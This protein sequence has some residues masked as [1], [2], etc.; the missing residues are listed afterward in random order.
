MNL[1][2]LIDKLGAALGGI[3]YRNNLIFGKS[4]DSVSLPEAAGATVA[5]VD[6]F[7]EGSWQPVQAEGPAGTFNGG[8]LAYRWLGY[9]KPTLLYMHGS[10]E[11]PYNFGRFSDNSFKKIFSNAVM[12]DLNLFLL[13]AP[14]HDRSQGEYIKALG[15]LNNYVGILSAA[16]ATIDALAGRLKDAGC[17]SIYAAGFSLGG[18]ALN[19]HR[20]FWSRN[21]DRYLPICAGTKPSAVFVESEYRKLT[22]PAARNKP[23]L[24]ASLLDFEAYFKNNTKSDCYPLMFRFD[25]LTELEAQQG[26]YE[27]MHM[28]ILEKGHFT[29]QQAIND[30]RKHITHSIE[31]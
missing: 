2:K 3:V 28:S 5:K 9:D 16:A 23:Q 25:L 30:F 7:K 8:Y 10:G 13:A 17:P 4:L 12:P 20:A 21:V 27:G 11:Q 29:G 15:Y 26:A 24:L 22:A 19:V 1:H 14:F 6:D 18:W 31:Q